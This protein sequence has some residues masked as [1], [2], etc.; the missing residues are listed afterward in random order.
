M[1][2]QVLAQCGVDQWLEGDF[3]EA[4]A[5][6]FVDAG[7]ELLLG[8]LLFAG[9]GLAI[10]VYTESVTVPAVLMLLL[11]GLIISFI[12][13]PMSNV[14]IMVL[15]ILVGMLIFVLVRGRSV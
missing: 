7:G 11:G 4:V 2:A 3:V 15:V 10:A 9:L 14:A 8:L 1:I 5:C 6:P 13:G 12:P